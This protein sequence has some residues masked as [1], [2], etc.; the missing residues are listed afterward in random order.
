LASFRLATVDAY[1]RSTL[2]CGGSTPL[3]P[4]AEEQIQGGVE[5]PHSKVLCTAISMRVTVS[6]PATKD[7]WKK[8]LHFT[9]A[10]VLLACLTACPA[11]AA[12]VLTLQS[13]YVRINLD[14][15]GLITSITSRQSGKEYLAVGKPSP[16]LSLYENGKSLLPTSA[17]YN[18]G[19]HT[20]TL[21][22]PNGASATVKVLEK[23]KYFRLQLV[24][25]QRRGTVNNI[26][27][28]P[29]H[30]TLSKTIGDIIGVVRDDEWAI[31]MLA[32]DDRTTQGPPA[33]SDF[34]QMYYYI[35]SP[36]PAKYPVPAQYTEG[37]RFT[38]GGNGISDVAF[39]S[40]PEEYFHMGFESGALLEPGSGSVITYHARDRRQGYT[41]FYTLIPGLPPTQPRHQTVD[42]VAVDFVGSSVALYACP[43][44]LGLSV[45]E[46]I[47]LAEGLPHPTIN[48]NWVK[49]P[50]AYQPDIFWTGPH[51]QLI[52]YADAL[53]LKGVQDDGMGEFYI[54]P[55]NHWDGPLVRFAD[56]R[57][58]TIREFTDQTRQHGILY[59]LHTLCMFVQ[60]KS[61]DVHPV[62]NEHFQTVLRTK[63]AG[64]LSPTDTAITVT[65]ASFL[66]EKGTWHD[67]NMNVLRIGTE[68][69]TYDGITSAPPW[70]L[71]NVKRGQFGTQASA[72]AA[73][74]ELV[75]LQITCYHGF[76]PD[77]KLMTTYADYYAQRLSELG[78]EYVDFDGFESCMYQN[79]GDYAFKVFL[80]R[81]FATYHQLSG[82]RYLRIMGST[83]T[84]GSWHYMSVCNVGGG[85]NM[86]D[87]GESHWG[88]EGKDIRYQWGSSYFPITFGVQRYRGDWTAYDAENLEA[89]SIGWNATYMLGLNQNIVE[90]SGE[91]DAIFKAIRTWEN[92]RGT[93]VFTKQDKQNLMDLG[94]K[95]HLEQTGEKSFFLSPVKEIGVADKAD[96]QVHALVIKNPYNDQ[97]LQCALRFDGPRDATLEGLTITLPGGQQV[98]SVRKMNSGEFIIC[99]G[100]TAYVADRFRKKTADLELDRPATLPSGGTTISVQS[101]GASAPEKSR[102]QITVW[103]VGKAEPVG[104]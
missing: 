58:M 78:M 62:P 72:H 98:K 31:G 104:K 30:T 100:N 74:D 76:I 59:G 55:S 85:S 53:G 82:G 94:F 95:F 37:E 9:L 26:V 60:T 101:L 63:L 89:K 70:T 93:N 73:G 23:E 92:A 77:M 81:L 56:G 84:E 29:I 41:T 47:V 25:L 32:L 24:A 2:E 20:L 66:A 79:Q 12:S 34:G 99:T 91:K 45:I 35:H 96:N 68:L 33:D 48:G 14:G 90:R 67:N 15:R 88:I 64:A 16:I 11:Q 21:A 69:L 42:P 83:V 28:G 7:L 103:A 4:N 54:D 27:W 17:T 97:P 6:D 39:Y 18:R 8:E 61:S 49:D 65:D 1:V 10:A 52:A 19:Q 3:L 44:D 38:I 71:Q 43:D 5:P 51:D 80:E 87:P 46:N 102:L 50:A 36:D 13:E 22:Y 75:K 86:F 40:H 57:R